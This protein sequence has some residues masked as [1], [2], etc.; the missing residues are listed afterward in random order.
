MISLLKKEGEKGK[1]TTGLKAVKIFFLNNYLNKDQN[2][3]YYTNVSRLQGAL[4][5][6]V[7]T[8]LQSKSQTGYD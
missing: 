5:H 1:N 2:F 8:L 6:C 4:M 7:S 3:K